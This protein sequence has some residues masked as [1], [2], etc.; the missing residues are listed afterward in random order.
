MRT[1]QD[2]R[3]SLVKHSELVEVVEVVPEVAEAVEADEVEVRLNVHSS[4]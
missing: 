2:G 3:T 4:R 1:P